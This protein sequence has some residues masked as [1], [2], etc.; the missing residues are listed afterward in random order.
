MIRCKHDDGNL[1]W[2]ENGPFD[3]ILLTC[4]APALVDPLLMQLADP[5]VFISPVGTDANKQ[6]LVRIEKHDGAISEHDLGSVS[7]VPLLPGVM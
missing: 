4:A 6:I 5:G 7:F 3:A 2:A 1:G